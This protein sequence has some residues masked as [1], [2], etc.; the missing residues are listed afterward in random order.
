MNSIIQEYAERH[1]KDDSRLIDISKSTILDLDLEPWELSNI[2]MF[3]NL[4]ESNWSREDFKVDGFKNYDE[5]YNSYW[6]GILSIRAEGR[7]REDF[8]QLA[9]LWEEA[10]A[11]WESTF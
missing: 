2:L 11:A 9:H 3:L 4:F 1:F 7:N 8:L 6:V 5:D 10:E